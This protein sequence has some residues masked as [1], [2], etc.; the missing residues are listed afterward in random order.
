MQ[1]LRW[2]AALLT[3]AVACSSVLVWYRDCNAD[4]QAW[5]IVK[6]W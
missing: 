3:L 2:R 6:T 4:G 5:R 1:P